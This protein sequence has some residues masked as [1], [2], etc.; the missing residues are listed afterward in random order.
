[1][2]SAIT[3]FEMVLASSPNCEQAQRG[4]ASAREAQERAIDFY[5]LLGVT[6]RSSEADIKEGYKR[7][8]REWHP[9]R[10]SDPVRKR[11]AERRMKNI[12]RALEVLGHPEKRHLYDQG[13]DPETGK[14]RNSGR[15][16]YGSPLEQLFQW[17]TRP[18]PAQWYASAYGL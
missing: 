6:H 1:M 13:R 9:D 11:E 7:A 14:Y 5:E 4:L 2:E 15:T 17:A 12:N 10:Y 3:D 18:D 8:A 16:S